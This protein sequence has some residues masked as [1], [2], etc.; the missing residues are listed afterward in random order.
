MHYKISLIGSGQIGGTA[1]LLIAQKSLASV[2][3]FDLNAGT[4]KGKALDIMQSGGV[5]NQ[6]YNIFGTSDYADITGSDVVIIT[7]GVPRKPGMTRD[8]L[9][10][11]NAQIIKSVASN[12]VKY[13][14]DAFIIIITNPLDA[15]VGLFERETKMPAKKIV[16]MAGVLDSAR[17]K[18]FLAKEFGVSVSS[19]NACVMGGH[20]DTMVPLIRYSTINGVPIM[21]MVKAG[22]SSV[23]A[24]NKIVQRTRDGGAE[25][26][27]LLGNGSAYYAPAVSAVEMAESYLLGLN[28]ILPCATKLN[29]EYGIKDLYIGVSALIG[30]G[31]VEKIIELSLTP[32][33]Q[34]MLDKSVKSVIELNNLLK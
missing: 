14:P 15:M 17:F 27:G 9:L 24:I 4:A 23:D 1:S 3:M 31:G 20:G 7:A 34:Q 2:V 19:V 21:D 30:I 13:A 10:N 25:I 8:D 18:Y 26:V 16:G 11:I 12:V 32:D 28:K 5:V 29:G 22:F 33:E 6:D